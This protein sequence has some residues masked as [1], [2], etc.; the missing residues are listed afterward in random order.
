[1]VVAVMASGWRRRT[2]NNG[3]VSLPA[4][5]VARLSFS[6]SDPLH[7]RLEP[8]Q[9]SPLPPPRPPSHLCLYPLPSSAAATRVPLAVG[10]FSFSGVALLFHARLCPADASAPMVVKH[11]RLRSASSRTIFAG[12][13]CTAL[14]PRGEEEVAEIAS[15][16]RSGNS[17]WRSSSRLSANYSSP[18]LV[19]IRVTCLPR[20]SFLFFLSSLFILDSSFFFP[21]LFF[22][23]LSLFLSR[24]LE[25]VNGGKGMLL[26]GGASRRRLKE[27]RGRWFEIVLL[28]A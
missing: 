1:M 13:S 17:W 27:W 26:G 9:R 6:L 4:R 11:P 3:R 7:P 14:L 15:R 5:T 19:V 10:S 24:R 8:L 20:F 2:F 28:H 22:S 18:R 21:S 23:F 12:T 16:R 25:F